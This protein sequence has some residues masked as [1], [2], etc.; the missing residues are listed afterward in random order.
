MTGITREWTTDF[1]EERTITI[2]RPSYRAFR[3]IATKV[4]ALLEVDPDV[5]MAAPEFEQV[6]QACTQENL[7]DWLEAAEYQEVIRL[8]DDIIS[9]CEFE[10]FFAERQTRHFE[11]SKIRMERE[12][13][14]Q[15]AQI[16][17]MKT[18]GLLPET[19]SLDS[20]MNAGMNLPGIPLTSPSS[21]TS[22]PS[23]T[24]GPEPESSGKT[25]GSSSGTTPK[26]S[27]GGKRS[28][29]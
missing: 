20:V 5:A 11:A 10:S 24:D 6:I 18:S 2:R 15:A 28:K 4:S 8:W 19:F 12:V 13:E 29:S 3:N 9:F 27:G 25:S 21:S 26:Q 23:T 14:L 7:D 17:K 1:P 22:T 16:A